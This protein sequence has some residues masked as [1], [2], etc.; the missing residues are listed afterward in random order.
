MRVTNRAAFSLYNIKLGYDIFNMEKSYYADGE[1]AYS[2]N[3]YFDLSIKPA[4]FP[5]E[6]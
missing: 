4:T 6:A 5:Y 2:M 3:K 1:D